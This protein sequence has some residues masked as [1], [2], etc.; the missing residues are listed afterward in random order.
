[1]R[2]VTLSSLSLLLLACGPELPI[3]SAESSETGECPAGALGCPCDAEDACADEGLCIAGIC[4]QV[5]GRRPYRDIWREELVVPAAGLSR[6]IVGGRLTNDNFVNRGD[7]EILHVEGSTQIVVQLQRFTFTNSA[8][9]AEEAFARM[10]LWAYGLV[11]VQRPDEAI[12]ARTTTGC[13]SLC[14]TAPTS[15]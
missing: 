3:D 9:N 14:E 15:A 8:E 1:M 6:L 11:D 2:L 12:A 5:G 13:S 4:E 7:I 10:S